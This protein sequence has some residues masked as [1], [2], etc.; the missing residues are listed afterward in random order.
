MQTLIELY[1]QKHLLYLFLPLA[2]LMIIIA[3][4]LAVLEIVHSNDKVLAR[5]YYKLRVFGILPIAAITSIVFVFTAF[6]A[7]ELKPLLPIHKMELTSSG[8]EQLSF[9]YS[10]LIEEAESKC[11][12]IGF[13]KAQSNSKSILIVNEQK[14][15]IDSCIILAVSERSFIDYQMEFELLVKK[16]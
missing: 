4:V 3:G 11:K 16:L 1:L 5:R 7:E 12:L 14:I 13:Y 10:E 8:C 15:V 2:V 6:K 9:E